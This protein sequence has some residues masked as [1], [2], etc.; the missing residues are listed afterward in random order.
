M[1]WTE[2]RMQHAAG[3][4]KAVQKGYRA[5]KSTENQSSLKWHQCCGSW[6][7]HSSP[8]HPRDVVDSRYEPRK[9]DSNPL[10]PAPNNM[11]SLGVEAALG[12]HFW[13]PPL[14]C[15][16]PPSLG[17]WHGWSW[18]TQIPLETRGCAPGVHMECH[19][20]WR[21]LGLTLMAIQTESLPKEPCRCGVLSTECSALPAPRWHRHTPGG[22]CST[23][24][25]PEA[26]PEDNSPKQGCCLLCTALSR[27]FSLPFSFTAGCQAA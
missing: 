8:I 1:Q 16:H 12:E 17:S 25:F 21:V 27:I 15:P 24:A 13:S 9:R 6:C 18:S 3:W 2:E 14:S 5:N 10:C 7:K 26:S 11:P 22:S 4:A 19:N 23:K 20:P